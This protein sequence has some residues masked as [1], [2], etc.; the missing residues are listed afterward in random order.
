M[1]P[2]Q[3]IELEG[4]WN[5]DT[6]K[7][8]RISCR[9]LVMKEDK[10]LLSYETKTGLWMIPGGGLEEGETDVD[11]CVREVGEETGV[12]VRP[13]ACV[14][15]LRESFWEFR[16]AS[17]YFTA[18]VIGTSEAKRTER[19]EKAGMEPRWITLEEALEAFSGE[20]TGCPY[21]ERLWRG[22]Y[23]REYAALKAWQEMRD[24]E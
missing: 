21:P 23:K 2:M 8:T 22:L 4:D 19:E 18:E 13:T 9:G 12:L 3:I 17:R 7:R 11:C 5:A 6:A 15:E 14:L 20:C 10:L 1:K 24:A 16:S